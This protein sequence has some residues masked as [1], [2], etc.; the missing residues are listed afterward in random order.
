MELTWEQKLSALNALSDHQL[1]QREPGNWYIRAHIEIG[2]DGLL[3]SSY[4]NGETVEE[5][6]LNHWDKLT[7]LADHEYLV[8]RGVGGANFY[9]RWNGFMWANAQSMRD[10]HVAKQIGAAA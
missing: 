7:K 1:L 5:A 6:V 3:K 9:V 10:R 4:G 8:V 2:G